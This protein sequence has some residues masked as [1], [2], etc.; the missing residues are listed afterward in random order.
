MCEQNQHS[1]RN[2]LDFCD[3]GLGSFFS[4]GLK[5]FCISAS[6]LQACRLFLGFMKLLAARSPPECAGSLS[7]SDGFH[8]QEGTAGAR[9]VGL[10]VQDNRAL[11]IGALGLKNDLC[12]PED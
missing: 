8:T 1:L 10:D 11:L 4:L 7:C 3:S 9:G 6:K 12:Q 5:E 2:E